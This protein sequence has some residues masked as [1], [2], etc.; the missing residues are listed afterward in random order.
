MVST[1]EQHGLQPASASGL[2]T[3]PELGP[4]VIAVRAAADRPRRRRCAVLQ[5]CAGFF[6]TDSKQASSLAQAAEDDWPPVLQ[7]AL[8]LLQGRS[9]AWR[10][11]GAALQV[12][13]AV[14]G[15]GRH[16]SRGAGSRS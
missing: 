7:G 15:W 13:S 16:Y 14:G 1:G 9:P 10:A 2:F 6:H 4:G 11:E 5:S 3:R 12:H 8:G